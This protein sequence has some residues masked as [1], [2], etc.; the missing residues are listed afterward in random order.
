MGKCTDSSPHAS[1]AWQHTRA[2]CCLFT[3]CL[4]NNTMT[5][6]NVVCWFPLSKGRE[7]IACTSCLFRICFVYAQPYTLPLALLCFCFC[8]RFRFFAI[9]R[10]KL[11]T[12][13]VLCRYR[14]MQR[15]DCLQTMCSISI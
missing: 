8:S 6:L 3:F 14:W 1:H 11:S 7:P 5:F 4:H 2:I 10:T 12:W 15:I 13:I 9:R